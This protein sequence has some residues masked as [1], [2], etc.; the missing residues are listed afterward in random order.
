M[1][2]PGNRSNVGLAMYAKQALGSGKPRAPAMKGE[3]PYAQNNAHCS[4][5]KIAES[6]V[7]ELHLHRTPKTEA[8]VSAP[9][10]GQPSVGVYAASQPVERSAGQVTRRQK[11]ESRDS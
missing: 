3:P 4:F 5:D 9:N 8:S 2:A 1:M 7:E 10:F 6:S 11:T